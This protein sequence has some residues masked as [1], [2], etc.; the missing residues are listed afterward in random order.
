MEMY[1]VHFIHPL[2]YF[3]NTTKYISRDIS[4]NNYSRMKKMLFS[5]KQIDVNLY[6]YMY[7]VHKLMNHFPV[8]RA[9]TELVFKIVST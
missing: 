1:F 6:L 7:D 3:N 9:A 5:Q 4:N 2:Q 8:W